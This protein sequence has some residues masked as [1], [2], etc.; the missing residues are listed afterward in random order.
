MSSIQELAGDR[1]VA[2]RAVW[3]ALEPSPVLAF[4]YLPQGR[5]AG[6][7]ADDAGGADADNAGGVDAQAGRR[8]PV[9]LCPTFGWEEMCS[10]RGRRVWAQALARAGHPTATF[11]LPGSGDSG[12]SP[13]RPRPAGGLDGGGGADRGVAGRRRPAPIAS[14]R[15]A[16]VWAG[17]WPTGR[18][19][20]APRSTI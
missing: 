14:R 15:L 20:P 4:L 2:G 18:W 7:D 16:S 5:G 3:L 9:L 12:G 17:C 1:A 13:A 10:Y 19:P 11:G 8:A 6:V